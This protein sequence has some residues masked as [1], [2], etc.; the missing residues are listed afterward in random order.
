MKRT[1]Y[2]ESSYEVAQHYPNGVPSTVIAIVGEGTNVFVSS[3]NAEG[4]KTQQ[5]FSADLTNDEIVEQQ[6]ETAYT[7]GVAAG[8]AYYIETMTLNGT[9]YITTT[10]QY[11]VTTYAYAQVSDA[12]LI[13]SN[14]VSGTSIL[15]VQGSY[16][17]GGITPSGTEYIVNTELYDVTDYAYAQV[18]DGYLLSENIKQGVSILGVLGSYTGLVPEGT[19]YINANTV[20]DVTA[21]A[22]AYCTASSGG[23]QLDVDSTLVTY[24]S[25]WG[26]RSWAENNWYPQMS[27]GGILEGGSLVQTADISYLTASSLFGDYNEYD[28]DSLYIDKFDSTYNTI[29][30]VVEEANS[31]VPSTSHSPYIVTFDVPLNAGDKVGFSKAEIMP[32]YTDLEEPPTVAYTTSFETWYTYNNSHW[33]TVD[34]TGL[35]RFEFTSYS[36]GTNSTFSYSYYNTNAGGGEDPGEL[37]DCPYCEGTGEVNGDVCPVCT[38]SGWAPEGYHGETYNNDM[39]EDDGEVD[40]SYEE[41]YNQGWIDAS[42]GTNEN[43]DPES[44]DPEQSEHPYPYEVGYCAGQQDWANANVGGEEPGEEISPCFLCHGTGEVNG[45]TCQLCEGS[46]EEPEGWWTGGNYKVD[47]FESVDVSAYDEGY[48]QGWIDARDGNIVAYD[49]EDESTWDGNPYPYV[50]G[51]CDGGNDYFVAN[52]G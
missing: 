16:E 52:P 37:G 34:Q 17:G 1:E 9:S 26:L 21:Y 49:P 5:Y 46:G 44:W 42:N 11:D 8:E 40:Q 19:A 25:K 23:A 45:D 36:G 18:S 51:Y 38:G 14:I 50:A 24:A 41:G 39:I 13:P 2:F 35:Y 3:D 20:T 32:V 7:A 29:S 6:V 28:Q 22:Y 48:T 10:S 47:Q 15:G 30:Q 33:I 43:Y 27:A 12:N 4:D 31:F